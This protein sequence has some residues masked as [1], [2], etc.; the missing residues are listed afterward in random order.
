[1]VAKGGKRS[2]V[3]DV[4]NSGC[5]LDRVGS[6]GELLAGRS[7]SKGVFGYSGGGY[8]FFLLDTIPGG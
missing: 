2:P 5:R 6:L 4:W 3:S 8:R 7:L 1:M